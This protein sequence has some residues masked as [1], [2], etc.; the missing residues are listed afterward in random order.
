MPITSAQNPFGN[1]RKWNSAQ[2]LCLLI[3]GMGIIW[4]LS[5]QRNVLPFEGE[6]VTGVFVSGEPLNQALRSDNPRLW[7][8]IVF[9][10]SRKPTPPKSHK[11]QS[12]PSRTH[13]HPA[14]SA[15]DRSRHLYRVNSPADKFPD[16]GA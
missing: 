1:L 7:R 8:G 15:F 2:Y 11:L 4:G 3:D 12:S 6:A 14:G 10:R 5:K 16:E 9:R 13:C